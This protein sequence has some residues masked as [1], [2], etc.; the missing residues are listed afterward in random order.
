MLTVPIT[1]IISLAVSL[2][3]K[4]DK[5][6]KPFFYSFHNF[7]IQFRKRYFYYAR[8]IHDEY[9]QVRIKITKKNALCITIWLIFSRFIMYSMIAMEVR[10]SDKTRSDWV[11]IYFMGLL[12][13]KLISS[14][15]KALIDCILIVSITKVDFD[16]KLNSFIK[17]ILGEELVSWYW[18]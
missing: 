2:L 13:S 1:T 10:I 6:R 18:I 14:L 11:N 15:I 3:L 7:L 8:T 17:L 4:F 9:E 12:P 16:S 5:P